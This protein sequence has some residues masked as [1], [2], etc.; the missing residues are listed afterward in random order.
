MASRWFRNESDLQTT[1]S[2]EA[3]SQFSP[4][5]EEGQ[6]S[7]LCQAATVLTFDNNSAH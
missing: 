1:N 2:T 6:R 4:V 7:V 3:G 5:Y